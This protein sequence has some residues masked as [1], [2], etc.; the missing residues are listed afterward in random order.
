MRVCL[1]TR[2]T[3]IIQTPYLQMHC[4]TLSDITAT[5]RVVFRWPK[6]HQNV[7]TSKD[8]HST[9]GLHCPSLEPIQYTETTDFT[10]PCSC[11]CQNSIL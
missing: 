5:D 6:I 4:Y 1:L 11:A 10:S 3:Q 7:Q 8:T 2:V 9:C